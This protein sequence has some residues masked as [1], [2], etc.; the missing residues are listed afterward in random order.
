ME[1]NQ[2]SDFWAIV[3]GGSSG[4]GLATVEKLARHRMNIAVLYRETASSER[5]VKTKYSELA[6][7]YGIKILS[8]NLN[9]LDKED[10]R[11]FIM[12]FKKESNEKKCIRLLVHS[13]ARG[14]LKPLIHENTVSEMES[15]TNL[16]TDD[17]ANTV[18]AMSTSL[19][20]WT[21]ELLS[22]DLFSNDTRI[23]GLTSEGAHKYWD[24][25]AAVSI[26][27]ASLENL[28]KYMSVEFGK[29]GIKTNLIQAGVT[30]TPSLKRIPG[31]EELIALSK[32]RNPSGRM[33]TPQDVANVIYLLCTEEAFWI[34]GAIIHVD[35]GEHSR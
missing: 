33:T 16:S 15:M 11:S 31:S 5:V 6:N 30:E 8:F 20:D 28:A 14:N 32:V 10:R 21:R 26:A 12:Q 29:F 13:I 34:N 17:I 22:E 18:Y 25:Y 1:I 24:S 4:I 9:A 35:G 23:V 2:L 27:K 3:L 19:L 7:E